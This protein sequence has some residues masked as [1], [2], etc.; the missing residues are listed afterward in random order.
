M[1][2]RLVWVFMI[3][4]VLRFGAALAVQTYLDRVAHRE[5]LIPGDANGYWELG[6]KL[7]RGQEF[8][9]YDPPRRVMRMPGFPLLLSLSVRLFGESLFAA[10]CLLAIVGAAA[11]ALTYL[12]GRALFD[13]R[14]GF[15]AGLL[16]AVSPAQIGFSV[17]I[18]SET[19]FG[20]TMLVSLWLFA[21]LMRGR[22]LDHAGDSAETTNSPRLGLALAAGCGVALA[23]Y[24][25]PTWLLAGPIFVV[26]HVGFTAWRARS[27]SVWKTAGIEAVCVLLG[28][29]VS[30]VPWAYR[31]W[32][33]VGHAIPTTLWVGPSL[34]DGLHPGATGDSDM[35]F[36][37]DDRLMAS[38]SEYDMDQ[39]YRRRA[40]EFARANP[41]RA[42]EL[43]FIKLWRFW[44]P[45][46]NAEQFRRWWMCAGFASYFFAMMGLLVW[47][48]RRNGLDPARLLLLLGPVVY[49]AAVHAVFIGSIRYR[50]PAE[51]PMLVL[52]GVG[53]VPLFDR[54][55]NRFRGVSS[56]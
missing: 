39:E 12:L 44:S 23:T 9:I 51:F 29:A 22:W 55:P 24:F 49:F 13:E 56:C 15:G 42:M 31:N 21:R 48:L 33:V 19:A 17:E 34:Y 36:F 11:C 7:A 46:P 6:C 35:Q 16:A 45:W 54:L 18:L 5:F 43:G 28:L 40:I 14:A 25:R 20:L 26:A 38:M 8:S 2:A 41:L 1:T 4:L 52:S 30:L 10:R 32:Q 47:G 27:R 53:L 50:L 37:E 3:A